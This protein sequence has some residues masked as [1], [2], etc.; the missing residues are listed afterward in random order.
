MSKEVKISPHSDDTERAILGNLI[1]KPEIYDEV[2]PFLSSKYFYGGKNQKL[3]SI[4]ESMAKSGEPIDLVTV[5]S[6]SS[7]YKDSLLTSYYISEVYS[8]GMNSI[9]YLYYAKKVY[10]LYLL[11]NV[12]VQY[13]HTENNHVGKRGKE[14]KSGELS[15]GGDITSELKDFGIF[16]LKVLA[17]PTTY[18]YS[19]NLTK[20]KF[21]F[22]AGNDIYHQQNTPNSKHVIGNG[23]DFVI[24]SGNTG[25]KTLDGVLDLLREIKSK[26]YSR[27]YI[28]DEYRYPNEGGQRNEY[29]TGPHIH[30]DLR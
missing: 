16:F 24:T 3:F 30:I 14:Y 18:G 6:R 27:L 29:T 1:A 10:E 11:R 9:N 5:C 4:I 13:G 28:K 26:S 7:M 23:L 20:V 25:N 15:S 22:T 2:A 21:R 12:I 19:H 17:D 8:N